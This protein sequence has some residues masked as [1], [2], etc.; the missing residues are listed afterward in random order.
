MCP[1]QRSKQ[2]G[3]HPPRLF[4]DVSKQSGSMVIMALFLIIVVGLLAVTLISIVSASSNSSIHQVYG[5][6]AQQA[7]QSG[8]QSL[9]QASFPAGGAAQSCNQTI[10]NPASMSSVEGLQ[11]CSFSATCETDSIA[12]AN[13][14]YLY[15]KY[16][17]TGSCVIN[18]SVISRT[19]SV[20][21]MQELSP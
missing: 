16:T 3:K 10:S 14:D 5:L 4:H 2:L 1:K 20:D 11:S 7:A 8:V 18:N 6:R 17:S 9:L 21:A 15:F 19:L 13:V 12:F